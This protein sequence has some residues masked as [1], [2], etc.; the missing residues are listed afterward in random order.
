M[1][2]MQVFLRYLGQFIS[3]W[4]QGYGLQGENHSIHDGISSIRKIL[5]GF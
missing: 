4:L 5:H 3:L 1:S 2:Q